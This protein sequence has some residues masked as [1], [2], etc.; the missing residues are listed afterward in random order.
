M[1][2]MTKVL[3]AA[4]ALG[5]AVGMAGTA[6]ANHWRGPGYASS[7]QQPSGNRY[8]VE[9]TCSGHR[10]YWAQSRLQVSLER[11]QIDPWSARRIQ[12]AIDRLQYREEHECR[13]GDYRAAQVIGRE[14]NRIGDWIA[15]EAA[16]YRGNSWGG[17]YWR[18]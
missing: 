1:K 18:R 3:T 11:G 13:E 7:W 8:L 2:T 12:T 4:I 14:Y 16:S 15:R 5:S 10:A 6:S 17:G 9:T